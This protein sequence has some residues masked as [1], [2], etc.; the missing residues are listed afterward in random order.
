MRGLLAGGLFL[1]GVILPPHLDAQVASVNHPFAPDAVQMTRSFL[2][3]RP[4]PDTTRAWTMPVGPASRQFPGPNRPFAPRPRFGFGRPSFPR[5]FFSV[6]FWSPLLFPY[7][8]DSPW[9]WDAAQNQPATAPEPQA[10]RALRRQMGRLTREITKL[11]YY[12]EFSRQAARATPA[13]ARGAEPPPAPVVEKML[14]TIFVYHDGRRFEAT[15]Y[16]IFGNTLWI[17]GSQT[18]R[19]IPLAALNLTAS[20][21]L[22]EERGVNFVLPD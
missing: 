16:A 3:I 7:A 10:D 1:A 12:E 8:W 6:V 21:K 19:K 11:R 2:P 13:P 9:D 18:A 22:N 20:Q 5:P 17:F 4:L 15:D 14:P